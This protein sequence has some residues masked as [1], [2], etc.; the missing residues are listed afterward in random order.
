MST[1]RKRPAG[2]GKSSGQGK[3]SGARS[4]GRG[5]QPTRRGAQSRTSKSASG[6]TKRS[7]PTRT[8]APA[9]QQ[10]IDVHDPDGVR[11]QKLLAAAGVGSRRQ[12]E[13]LIAE[14]RVAV[15][16]VVVTE[17]GVRIDPLRQVVHVDGDRVQ[18]DE[19]R[20]YLAF[21]KPLGVVTSMDDELGRADISDFL[22][23]RTERLFHVGRLD[24][25]TEGLL[26]LTNDGDLAHRL[27]HPRYGVLKTYLA[28]VPGPLPRD[29]GKRLRAGIELEDGPVAVDSFK[30]IDSQPGKALVEVV[31]HEGRKHIVR[32]M[33]AE[34]G[35]PVI[36]L[37]RTQV[38]PVRLGDTRSGRWRALSSAEV[39]A[40]YAAAGL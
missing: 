29:L 26:L 12:C 27:Q 25:D 30:V 23:G 35:H 24:A 18:L 10:D 16:G 5:Q 15:D 37:V 38:G 8:V 19:S 32:R 34:V 21:N 22:S 7:Q 17:L 6:S 20:V 2:S 36:S 40:L 14:G 11:L 31:L 28:Q 1:P 4:G 33:L 13:N 39:S 3:G 9:A